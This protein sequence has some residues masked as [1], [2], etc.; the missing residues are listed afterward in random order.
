MLFFFSSRRRHTR[1]A[2]VT[3]VQTCALPIWPGSH[4]DWVRPGGAL[5]GMSVIAGRTAA[6]FGLQPVMTFATRLLAVN[7]I[8][9]GERLG[10]SATWET[11]EDMRICVA[12]VGHG[13]ANPPPP[14][15]GTPARVHGHDRHSP[16]PVNRGSRR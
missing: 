3:G 14:P 7:R 5:Y 1:C 15:A 2:L 9:H 6:D 10:Y 8:G 13:V 11:P 16:R 4:G 12:A